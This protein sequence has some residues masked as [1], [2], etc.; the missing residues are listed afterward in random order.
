[1]NILMITAEMAPL[2]KV[3]GLADVVGALPAAL[4]YRGHDVRVVLPLYGHLDREAHGLERRPETGPL[5]LRVGQSMHTVRFWSWPQAAAGVQVDLV[6]CPGLFGRPGVYADPAGV[7]F[8]DSLERASALCAAA[9][10]LPELLDWPVDVVHAHDVQA[11]L[12]PVYRQW[13]YAGRGLPGPAATLLTI[14]NLAHQQLAAPDAVERVGLP[15][16]LADFPG[17]F[18]F[19]GQLNLLKAG[20]LAADR[21][22]TVSPTYAREVVADAGLGFGLHGVLA[23]RGEAFDGVLNGVDYRIWDPSRDGHLPAPYH[24]Q[25]LAGKAICRER[26]LEELELRPADGPLLGL[27]SRLFPQKGVDLVIDQLDHLV[28]DGFSLAVLGTGDRDLEQR[29]S[30]SASRHPDRVAFRAEFNE[31]LAH[32][33]YAGCDLLLMPSRF[34]PCGLPQLYAL[35]YGTPP[36]VRR[37]GGLADT[38]VDAGQNGGDGFVFEEAHGAAMHAALARAAALR[39]DPGRWRALQRR[40]MQR[41]F[42]WGAAAAAYEDRYRAL[43]PAG[44]GQV[45]R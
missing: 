44:D 37:T 11:A 15:R 36:V 28:A 5:P 9:L 26:L 18:E 43:V 42:S 6:E 31:G 1:M 20:I 24:H 30:E 45:V 2:A 40:G 4:A 8:G 33:I 27:V 13:W 39:A 38:V 19:Y 32:R 3:G 22:N 16:E 29:L 17:P 34:E 10:M 35:R 25:D 41:D 21:V 7:V 23:S 14:H 12:A